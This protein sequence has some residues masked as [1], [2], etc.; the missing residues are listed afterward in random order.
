MAGRPAQ[1]IPYVPSPALI[2]VLPTQQAERHAQ[3]APQFLLFALSLVAFLVSAGAVIVPQVSQ[4]FH[5]AAEAN[6]SRTMQTAQTSQVAPISRG[7]LDTVL[8]FAQ[9]MRADDTL[10]QVRAGV[11]AKRSNVQGVEIGGRTVYYDILPHQSYGPL[12][13]GRVTESDVNM[14]AR[15]TTGD[16]QIVVYSLR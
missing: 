8:S 3:N 1:S 16:S 5:R 12:R 13:A 7:D 9:Q 6:A 14:L 10:V 2:R 4:V 15:E 11:F